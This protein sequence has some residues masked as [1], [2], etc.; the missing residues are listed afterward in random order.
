MIIKSGIYLRNINVNENTQIHCVQ[1]EKSLSKCGATYVSSGV[2]SISFQ[3]GGGF[4]LFLEI[5]G[6]FAT[7][8]LGVFRGQGNAPPKFFLK[9]CNLL[10][11]GE[12]FAKILSKKIVKIFLFY[13]KIIENVLLNTLYLGLL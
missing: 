2:S 8:L 5:V 3:G 12:D 10:R 11:F 7:R 1:S 4:K 13:I 9:W 6:A